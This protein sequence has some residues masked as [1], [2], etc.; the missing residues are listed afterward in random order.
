MIG[1]DA[2]ALIDLV[3][4]AALQQDLGFGAHYEEGEVEGEH[5]FIERS[6]RVEAISDLTLSPKSLEVTVR[7]IARRLGD[8]ISDGKPVLDSRLPD[9]SRIAAVMPPCSLHGVTLTIR[10]FNAKHFGIEDLIRVGTITDELAAILESAVVTRQNILIRRNRYRQKTTLLD[11]TGA[12]YSGTPVHSHHRRHRRN[13]DQRPQPCPL[14]SASRQ[15]GLPAVTIRELLEASL[16]HRP[17]RILLGA[18]RGA[19]AFDLDGGDSS[20]YFASHLRRGL[21]A[22]FQN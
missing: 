22:L 3:G 4:V 6:G 14:R 11:H 13:S 5:V 17:V 7:I 9:G 10:K 15:N 12:I 8:D 2:G 20:T 21:R 18:I 1:T 16:R 19:E